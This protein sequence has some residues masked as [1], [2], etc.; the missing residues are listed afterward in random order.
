MFEKLAGKYFIRQIEHDQFAP[1]QIKS[2][3][4]VD[5]SNSDEAIKM[6]GLYVVVN[7]M[8]DNLKAVKHSKLL[9]LKWLMA[10]DFYATLQDL[11]IALNGNDNRSSS[12]LGGRHGN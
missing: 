4:L 5:G 7:V 3:E 12:I 9:P 11:D 1:A 8:T 10:S 6:N 2:I